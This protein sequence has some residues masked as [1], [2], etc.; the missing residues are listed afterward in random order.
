MKELVGERNYKNGTGNF[1]LLS[2]H[3][4]QDHFG[5]QISSAFSK[6]S[7][8][9]FHTSGPWPPQGFPLPQTWNAFPPKLLYMPEV[10]GGFKTTP[11]KHLRRPL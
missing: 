9:C 11:D 2:Q 7:T 5:M 1:K 10:Q 4:Q 6:N 8:L 3:L